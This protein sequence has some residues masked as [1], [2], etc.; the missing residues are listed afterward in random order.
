MGT[1]KIDFSKVKSETPLAFDALVNWFSISH[2]ISTKVCE[3]ALLDSGDVA[4][5]TTRL[6]AFFDSLLI[7]I[8][9]SSIKIEG[10]LK[11][12]YVVEH[13]ESLVNYTTRLECEFNAFM[14]A[15]YVVGEK[16]NTI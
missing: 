6:Y 3:E 7:E 9:I 2:S 8:S 10:C 11:F 13:S 14:K 16:L 1:D 12:N 4:L 5:S 15:F